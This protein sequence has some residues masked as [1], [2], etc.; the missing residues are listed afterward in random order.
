MSHCQWVILY[1]DILFLIDCYD[2]LTISIFC[3][4]PPFSGDPHS[5]SSATNGMK[6]CISLVVDANAAGNAVMALDKCLENILEQHGLSQRELAP[7]LD[8]WRIHSRTFFPIRQV[9]RSAK[10]LSPGGGDP[11]WA[12][13]RKDKDKRLQD[14]TNGPIRASVS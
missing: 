12:S 6:P 11:E 1:V 14:L 5:T 10:I 8:W 2:L 7:F 9:E 4:R 3:S 13:K